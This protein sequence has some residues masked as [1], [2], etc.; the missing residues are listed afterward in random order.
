MQVKEKTFFENSFQYKDNIM[1]KL[2]F[3]LSLFCGIAFGSAWDAEAKK[4]NVAVSIVPQV[5]FVEE[6][7]GDRVN[8][9]CAVPEGGSP[10]TYAPSPK[11]LMA[12]HS[13]DVYFTIGIPS[14][15]Y[16]ILDGLPEK[17]KVVPLHE[18]AAEKYPDLKIGESRD[19]HI[20]LSPKRVLVMLDAIAAELASLDPENGKE[21]LA[22]AESYKQKIE[23]ADAEAKQIFAQIP[24]KAFMVFHPAFG[25]LADEYGLTMYALEKHGKEASAKHLQEMVDI[26]KTNGVKVIF[27]QKEIAGRQVQAFAD[28]ISGK[29]VE[30]NPL[31]YDYTEN[32]LRLAKAM[33]EAM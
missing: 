20:W 22:N 17:V 30:L 14:E 18:K 3:I 2:V 24:Q 29:A 23:Q 5:K 33:Q 7:A 26:A 25:Y 31:A 13:A 10:E 6:I 1:K 4:L 32:L 28:E 11:E 16:N 15:K 12:L 9:L 8:I 27:Y 19:P 21:Y